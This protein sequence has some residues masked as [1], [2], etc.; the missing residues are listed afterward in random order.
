MKF[1]IFGM[2]SAIFAVAFGSVSFAQEIPTMRICSGMKN[3]N[4]EYTAKTIAGMA[5]ASEVTV[6][7]INTSGSMDNLKKI[8]SG[9]CDAA[10][11]QSDASYV[12]NKDVGDIDA[13]KAADLYT[14][15][16][17]LLCRRDTGIS[18][19]GGLNEKTKILIGPNGGGSAVTW[20][21]MVLADKEYGGD[22]YTKIPTLPSKNKASDL[23]QLVSGEADCLFYVGTPGNSLMSRDANKQGD[24]LGLVTVADKDFD[25]P[26]VTDSKGNTSSIWNDGELPYSSYGKIMPSGLFG[27]KSVNT[28]TVTAQ[29]LISKAFETDANDD[30]VA[31]VVLILP[32]VKKVIAA[33]KNLVLANQ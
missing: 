4:Y 31:S 32:D 10:I 22:Y 28:I 15:Y 27:R 3:G 19:L 33:D 23:V 18:D 5:D 11:V 17:H 21:G 29:F 25:D 16:A 24:T 2:L 13:M 8:A 1:M 9:E 12:Y 7:V 6:Q 30:A 14:E 20:R 26:T